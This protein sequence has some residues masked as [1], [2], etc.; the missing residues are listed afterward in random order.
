MKKFFD[1]DHPGFRPLWIRVLVTLV[2]LAWGVVEIATGNPFWA[3]IFLGLGAYCAY[4]FFFDFHPE[5][6]PSAR[7]PESPAE[8]E[9]D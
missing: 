5:N 4:A 8:S 9:G 3:M 7:P 6:H 2:C 1:T